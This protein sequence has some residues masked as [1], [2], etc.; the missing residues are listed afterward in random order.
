MK[1]IKVQNLTKIYNQNQDNEVVALND[2]SFTLPQGTFCVILGASGA[3]KS[4]L[5]N[6]LGGMDKATSGSY[7]IND[8]DVVKFTSQE[9]AVFRRHDIGFV[10]QFYN[11]MPNLTALENVE[12]AAS[13][14]LE[15]L[16]SEDIIN[17]V[18]LKDRKNSFPSQM[19]GGEQQ[20]VAIAR[21]VTKNPTLLLCD[22]PT[23][24]LDSKT[25]EQILTLLHDV[26]VQYN[27]TVIIVTHNSNIA[28]CASRVIKISDGKIIE[29]KINDK[30]KKP[31]E[32]EW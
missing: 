11:L 12:L 16:N 29:D 19:S 13:V 31:S 21:A 32:I 20:R 30:P 4:T 25:G 1:E 27:K 22:E 15:P 18:G 2:V 7:I 9:L 17:Q 24:A 6:I 28:E 5:L 8:K 26:S 23:G 10:F 14:A 3:G